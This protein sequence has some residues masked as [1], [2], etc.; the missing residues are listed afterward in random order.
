MWQFKKKDVLSRWYR[1]QPR[2]HKFYFTLSN[3]LR[4]CTVEVGIGTMLYMWWSCPILQPFWEQVHSICKVTSYSLNYTPA[5]FLLH[6]TSLSQ[7]VY[8]KSL[9]MCM[10][11]AAKL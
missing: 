11:N 5:Q 3:L 4:R 1:T 8:N 10:V 7:H 2:L 9:A 6:H